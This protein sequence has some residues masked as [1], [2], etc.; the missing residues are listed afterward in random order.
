MPRI[1]AKKKEYMMKDFHDWL[2]SKM[3]IQGVTQKDLAEKLNITQPA[4]CQRLKKNNFNIGDLIIIW[5]ELGATDEEILK[6]MKL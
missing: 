3:R 2:I 5:H 4:V 6:M 1:K